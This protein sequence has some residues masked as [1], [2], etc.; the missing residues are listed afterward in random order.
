MIG[1][2]AAKENAM[3]RYASRSFP[4][5]QAEGETHDVDTDIER[6]KKS[7]WRTYGDFQGCLSDALD[8]LEKKPSI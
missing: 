8:L 1:G 4:R 7:F 2:E 6:P 5:G 3:N